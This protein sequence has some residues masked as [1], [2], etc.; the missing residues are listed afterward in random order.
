MCSEPLYEEA[1]TQGNAC[2]HSTVRY[3]CTIYVQYLHICQ[4]IMVHIFCFF[5]PFF[6]IYASS[7]VTWFEFP[8]HDKSL[9]YHYFD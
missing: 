8:T 6:E 2:V 3:S 7:I 5:L 4:M 9:Y 1:H